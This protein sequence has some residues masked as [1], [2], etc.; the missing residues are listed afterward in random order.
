[1]ANYD[2]H[3]DAEVYLGGEYIGDLSDAIAGSVPSRIETAKSLLLNPEHLLVSDVE[4]GDNKF[5]VPTDNFTVEPT[6]DA[7]KF[8][9]LL[10][11]E[12]VGHKGRTAI[13]TGA[14]AL[15]IGASLHLAHKKKHK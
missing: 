9:L 12:I 11:E 3:P 1:M 13:I 5:E 8:R 6:E 2:S 4:I 7:S 10:K 15:A 14:A